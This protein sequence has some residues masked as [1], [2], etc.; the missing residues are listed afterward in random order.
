MSYRFSATRLLVTDFPACFRFYRD[1]LGMEATYG[2]ETDVYASFKLGEA[3]LE[4]FDRQAMADAIGAGARPV[5]AEAQDRVALSFEVDDVDAVWKDWTARGVPQA[6]PPTDRAD[7]GVRAA[8][9]RDPDG[10]L[11]EIFRTLPQS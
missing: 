3:L 7:W 5:Q 10:L 2:E 11:I 4:L 8:H 9:F 1:V 6:A